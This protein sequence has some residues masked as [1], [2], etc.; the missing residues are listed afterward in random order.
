MNLEIELF[1]VA[2]SYISHNKKVKLQNYDWLTG[3]PEIIPS[4]HLVRTYGDS[5]VKRLLNF[6][7]GNSLFNMQKRMHHNCVSSL[8]EHYFKPI[9]SMGFNMPSQDLY[10]FFSAFQQI[11]KIH[12]KDLY[13]FNFSELFAFIQSLAN[14]FFQ[15]LQFPDDLYKQLKKDQNLVCLQ[16]YNSIRDEVLDTHFPFKLLAYMFVRANWVDSYEDHKN[17]FL[18]S[19]VTEINELLDNRQGFNPYYD[20]NIYF[21]FEH[22]E[23]VLN[24]P[25]KTILYECDNNGEIFFDLLMVEYALIRGHQVILSCKEAP[26]LNDVIFSDLKTIFLSPSL[27]HLQVYLDSNQ[28]SLI[29][30]GTSDVIKMYYNVSGCYKKAYQSADI[31]ILKGQGNFLSYPI[32]TDRLVKKS[33]VRYYKPH[34]YCFGL[35][36]PTAFKAFQKINKDIKKQTPILFCYS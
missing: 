27:T 29:S 8:E 17:T 11:M 3:S 30:N 22:L 13:M 15:F 10:T 1:Q 19:L 26:I 23:N 32:L 36:S 14:K 5:P 35:K 34:F 18:D 25:K 7:F 2:R 28:L 6:G 12:W 16:I 21:N 4:Y 20:E 9:Q 33:Y 24:G 31:V